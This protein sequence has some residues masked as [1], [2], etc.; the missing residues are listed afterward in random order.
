MLQ[1]IHSV[2]LSF[3]TSSTVNNFEGQSPSSCPIL[4]WRVELN[5]KDEFHISFRYAGSD[6]GLGMLLMSKNGTLAML[7]YICKNKMV[8]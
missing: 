5:G 4:L 8:H 2:G 3:L 1:L 6:L 7:L